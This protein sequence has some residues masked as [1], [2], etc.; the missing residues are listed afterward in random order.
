MISEDHFPV[1]TKALEEELKI[2]TIHIKFY[3][4]LISKTK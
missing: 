4:I 1:W 3:H 2:S